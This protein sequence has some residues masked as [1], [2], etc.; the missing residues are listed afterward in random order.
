VFAANPEIAEGTITG[1]IFWFHFSILLLA[2]S[3]LFMETTVKKSNFTF[4]LPD[5]LL[6]LFIGLTLFNYDR[7]LNPQP[8]RLLFVGQLGTL[9]FML[10]AILQNH[11][12]LRLFFM[13]ILICTGI[14]EAMWGMGHLYGSDSTAHP[15][16][17]ADGLIFNPTPFSGY[18]AI[19]LPVCLN[20]ALRFRDCDK[21]A[22]WEFRTMVFY[23]AVFAIGVILIALP[24][25]ASRPA[26]LGFLP[27]EIRM[28]VT[29]KESDQT[30]QDRNSRGYHPV[31]GY[32]FPPYTGR[33]LPSGPIRQPDADV[34][35]NDQGH[36]EPTSYRY[37]AG[38]LSCIIRSD[39][40]RIFHI[41][42]SI[43]NRTD[44]CRL[45]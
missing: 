38:R 3:V 27:S 13:S 26:L 2:F 41:G 43:R 12:E 31:F 28:G 18:L 21:M 22:W 16:L 44:G 24:G 4:S 7:E 36:S 42:K 37:G 23:L 30:Q 33:Y 35:R 11:S 29:E 25:G 15:L 14:F 6:L 9:W 34:E 10:R 5:G 40:S 45:P 39:T 32:F 1:K 19:I 17:K 8:E 20:L